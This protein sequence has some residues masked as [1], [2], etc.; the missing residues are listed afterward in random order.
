MLKIIK[1]SLLVALFGLFAAACSTD[2]TTDANQEPTDETAEPNNDEASTAGDDEVGND[3]SLF[4]LTDDEANTI[5][6]AER[7]GD[8]TA[9]LAVSVGGIRMIPQLDGTTIPVPGPATQS[10]GSGFIVDLDG[11]RFV[12]TNFHVVMD[13]VVEGTTDEVDDSTITATFG[14]N[15][16]DEVPLDVVGVNPSF[17]LALLEPSDPAIPL[18]DVEPIPLAD[19]DFVSKGQKAVALGNPFG[20]GIALTTG[21][22]SST[23][24]FVQSV[25]GVDVPMIQTD[26]SINP[27]NSGGPLIN[28]SG[29]LIGVNTAIFN[30]EA[31]AFAGI[32]FSVPSNLVAEALANLQLGGVSNLADTRPEFG[33]QLGTVSFLPAAVL[34]QAGLPETGVAILDITPGGPADAAGL[35]NPEG[36]ETIGGLPIPVNPDV[37][38]AIDGEPI[39][40]AMDLNAAV[41]FDAEIGDEVVVTIL[42]DGVELDVSVTLGTVDD[43]AAADEDSVVEDGEEN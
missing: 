13:T 36:F 32:G 11:T 26:A 3:D 38:V 15:E 6:I 2:A 18:P 14:D 28:S 10:S 4:G 30:P 22:I 42:R 43:V 25:G 12:V 17:D 27:G 37:I 19:S 35:Q 1:I 9:S 16:A 5:A 39:V 29:E 41:T 21:N 23:A 40:T 31:R 33:A 8:S 24:R 20:L 34:E 7:F